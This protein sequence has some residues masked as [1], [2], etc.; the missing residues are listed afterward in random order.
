[1]IQMTNRSPERMNT[2]FRREL[3]Q[4]VLAALI[5]AI[6]V[7]S[8][9]IAF[10]P[11]STIP[12]TRIIEGQ[13]IND[14]Q[15]AVSYLEDLEMPFDGMLLNATPFP[16]DRKWDF[17]VYSIGG[18]AQYSYTERETGLKIDFEDTEMVFSTDVNIPLH[19]ITKLTFEADVEVL[20]GTT[21]LSMYIG[22]ERW[23]DLLS[24]PFNNTFANHT[25]YTVYY[26]TC[27][28][29]MY[30]MQVDVPLWMIN[31]ATDDWMVQADFRIRLDSVL[32]SSIIIKSVQITAEYDIDL[33]PVTIDMKASD[34]N[35][36]YSNPY[37][38]EL[39]P[40]PYLRLTNSMKEN[41]SRIYIPVG[42]ET[43]YLPEG[44]YEG[45]IGW[46]VSFDFW[47]ESSI[48]FLVESGKKTIVHAPIGTLKLQIDLNPRVPHLQMSVLLFNENSTVKYKFQDG[49]WISFSYYRFWSIAVH[50]IDYLYIPA[51]MGS[52]ILGIYVM[53]QIMFISSET[54]ID[55]QQDI[56]GSNDLILDIDLAYFEFL[57]FA[58]SPGET[59]VITVAVSLIFAAI[60]TL[61]KNTENQKWIS[62]LKNVKSIPFWLS[63]GSIFVPWFIV[64]MQSGP[65]IDMYEINYLGFVPL[66]LLVSWNEGSLIFPT[67]FPQNFVSVIVIALFWVPFLAM[68]YILRED[69]IWQVRIPNLVAML[70]PLA[71]AGSFLI[72]AN[73]LDVPLILLPG[74]YLAILVPVSW[75]LT[76]A[77]KK[78][79]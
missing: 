78:Y 36:L 45:V 42:N 46:H 60:I 32:Y 58:L 72:V 31:N 64:N 70:G 33:Y 71:M 15:D 25:R 47:E 13:Q 29:E 49:P 21:N 41:Y 57:G 61:W 19:N 16:G 5:L 43:I 51:I 50:E 3:I 27:T 67:G 73:L 30:T 48:L 22:I 68:L 74:V 79:T 75:I 35:S 28:P 17:E 2:R 7:S 6:V 37:S 24:V 20:Q 77:L 10:V 44:E 34:G 56:S 4:S 40:T 9:I 23:K 18:V 39:G 62:Q 26:S 38:K 65:F 59:I 52:L 1:M 12:Q 55:I 63:L 66:L 8:A 11:M 53:D 14:Q 69:N 54:D 76:Y